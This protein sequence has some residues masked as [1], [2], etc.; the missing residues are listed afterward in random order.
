MPKKKRNKKS[1]SEIV[2]DLERPSSGDSLSDASRSQSQSES[3][4]SPNKWLRITRLISGGISSF[5]ALQLKLSSS[6]RLLSASSTGSQSA[7]QKP[8]KERNNSPRKASLASLLVPQ[9]DCD[10]DKQARMLIW[11]SGRRRVEYKR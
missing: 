3:C 8:H 4:P 9:V 1:N 5:E 6:L 2:K 10:C 11:F 7:R